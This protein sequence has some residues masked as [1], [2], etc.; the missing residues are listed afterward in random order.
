M[1]TPTD[2]RGWIKLHRDILAKEKNK[3]YK[4]CPGLCWVDLLMSA[5]W[6]PTTV[7]TNGRRVQLDR[8]EMAISL[9]DLQ[10]RWR[11]GSKRTVMRRLNEMESEGKIAIK[12][13]HLINVI[14]VV[15]YNKYQGELIAAQGVNQ[16]SGAIEGGCTT[17]YE[18]TRTTDCTTGCTTAYV[19][20]KEG[21]N[22]YSTL[23]H[24]FDF[25]HV[26]KETEAKF[27]G[28]VHSVTVSETE[29]KNGY[30]TTANDCATEA[31]V[32]KSAPLVEPT[33]LNIYNN[34]ILTHITRK[35]AHTRERAKIRAS[36]E[37]T[38]RKKVN[39]Q[40]QRFNKNFKEKNFQKKKVLNP[41]KIQKK[42]RN[43]T[44]GPRKNSPLKPL[45]T[46]FST[47]NT[48]IQTEKR[49]L[50][51]TPSYWAGSAACMS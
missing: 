15:D 9:V 29:L 28:Y 4:F 5:S 19:Y 46:P 43:K 21:C 30:C 47:R 14:K 49:I 12:R 48:C 39:Q 45:T 13:S 26:D 18:V 23:P 24:I 10:A 17:A 36:P 32:A 42:K 34:N 7:W 20:D 11:Y 38:L 25:E 1:A 35:C 2:T 51:N 41:T 16:C 27:Q 44:A 40:R 33:P 8:G 22:T 6:K 31:E 37:K 3:K 50:K